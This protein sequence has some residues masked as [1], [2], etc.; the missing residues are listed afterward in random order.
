VI[1]L[2]RKI[3]EIKRDDIERSDRQNIL[4]L[5]REKDEFAEE[6]ISLKKEVDFLNCQL[7]V[8]NII[9]I[10]LYGLTYC[11]GS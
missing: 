10:W 4:K 2:K 3:E 1:D 5:R 6:I 8:S 7:K 11:C 9:Y